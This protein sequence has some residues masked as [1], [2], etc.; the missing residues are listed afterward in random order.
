MTRFP[1]KCENT[2]FFISFFIYNRA[3]KST[4]RLYLCIW[5]D[6]HGLLFRQFYYH[7][8]HCVLPQNSEQE[9]RIVHR[10][11]SSY[12]TS[13]F[14]DFFL[15]PLFIIFF[16]TCYRTLYFIHAIL[17]FFYLFIYFFH[18]ECIEFYK[19]W[20]WSITSAIL[21]IGICMSR[22]RS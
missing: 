13:T 11:S 12:S 7:Y 18:T 10:G 9:F 20:T 4:C 21:F 19:I 15:H 5:P 8:K 22:F 2:L 14:V 6:G 1:S 17:I 16:N 3:P